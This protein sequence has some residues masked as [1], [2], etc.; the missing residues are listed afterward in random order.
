MKHSLLAA[1][2]VLVAGTT[3]AC[4]GGAPT[5]ASEGD[6]CANF[7]A[8]TKD[9]GD[10]GADAKDEDVVKALKGAGDQIE[11]TGTPKSMSEE[12]RKG[13]EITVKLIKELDDDATQDDVSKLDE[14]LSDT[15]KKQEEAFNTYISDTCNV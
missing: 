3:V 9:L 11:E 8:I 15:E 4:G 1:S 7:E 5:D 10:L 6:F 13:F 12:A 2:L 14:K